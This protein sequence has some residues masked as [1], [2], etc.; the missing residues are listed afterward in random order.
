M[1]L[2][3]GGA[4]V[5]TS[6]TV[7]ADRPALASLPPTSTPDAPAN[8]VAGSANQDL[9]GGWLMSSH[10]E[11]LLFVSTSFGNPRDNIPMLTGSPG[12]PTVWAPRW[13]P[14]PPAPT[15]R[16]LRRP[17][18]ISGTRAETSTPKW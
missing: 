13:P 11:Y 16:G 10:G 6:S 3:I 1:V 5:T 9:P 4:I 8:V 14:R 15:C 2:A 7:S 18:S 17:S 12:R